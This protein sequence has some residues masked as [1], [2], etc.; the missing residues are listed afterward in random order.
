MTYQ[1][2]D[3]FDARRALVEELMVEGWLT[4]GRTVEQ[5]KVARD[6]DDFAR[7]TAHFCEEIL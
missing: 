6:A 4:E 7:R 1:N 3:S 5:A 2:T